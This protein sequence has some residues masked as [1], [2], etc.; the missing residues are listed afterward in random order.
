MKINDSIT[1]AGDHDILLKGTDHDILLKSRNQNKNYDVNLGDERSRFEKILNSLSQ[2]KYLS[3]H[4]NTNGMNIYTSKATVPLTI[5]IIIFACL[6]S[7]KYVAPLVFPSINKSEFVRSHLSN[8]IGLTSNKTSKT[9]P[10]WDRFM[11]E[12]RIEEPTFNFT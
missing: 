4:Y 10:L 3:G 12:S 6:I 8:T 1:P 7:I 11:I 9:Y 2:P 5:F